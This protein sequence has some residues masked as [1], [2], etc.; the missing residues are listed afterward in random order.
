ML[1]HSFATHLMERG[2]HL[3]DIQELMRHE[4]IRSTQVYLHLDTQRA[5]EKRRRFH[6]RG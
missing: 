3:R 6:P 1:R 4:S 5:A 2:A